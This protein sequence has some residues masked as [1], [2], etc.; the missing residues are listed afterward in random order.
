ETLTYAELDQR[1]NSLAHHLITTHHTRP[2]DLIA[3]CLPR[4]AHLIT[5]L[6]AILKTGAAYVPLDPHYPAQRTNHLITDSNATLLITTSTT[7]APVS[8][9][10]T[11]LVDELEPGRGDLRPNVPVAPESLAYTIYTSGSTGRPKGVM[12]EHRQTTAMLTWARDTFP[13][14]V[15]ARTLASTSIC[16]DLSVFE[17]FAPL[18]TGGTVVLTPD[19]ALDL[20]HN[21]DAYRDV[22]LINTVPSIASELLAANA[23][24]PQARTINLAGEALSPKL[25]T[26]LLALPTVSTVNNL[27][28]PSED[29]T[30]STHAITT[31]NDPRT[32]IGRPIHGTTAHVLDNQ[33]NPV[34]LGTIGELYL[35]GAGITRG[36]HNQPATT[37]EKYLP[38]PNGQRLYRTGDL[39][40]WRTDGQL[41]YHGR[42]DNQTKIRGHRI[43]PEEIETVLRA[44]PEVTAATVAA[45]A[46]RLVGY[47][48]SEGVGHAELADHLRARLPEQ[49]VPSVFVDLAELPMTPNG[50]VDRN[51]LPEPT[52]ARA[53]LSGR[54]PETVDE[55]LVARVW[56]EVLDV[57]ESAIGVDD[58]FFRLGGHS[59]LA[60]RLVHRLGAALGAAVPLS[61][62]FDHPSVAGQARRLPRERVEPIPVLGRVA[63][64]D[65]SVVLPASAGQQRLWVLCQ[66]D[67]DANRAYHITGAAEVDGALDV[68]VLAEAV[69]RAAVRHEALRT[70]L[71]EVDEELVQVV[72]PEPRAGLVEGDWADELARPLNLG[73]GRALWKAVLTRTGPD[74]HVLG[75]SLHHAIADGWSVR[76]LLGEITEQYRALLTDPAAAEPEA[77]PVQFADVAAWQAGRRGDLAHWVEAS[78]GA[79]PLALATDRPRPARQTHGGAAVPLDLP[80]AELRAVASGAGTSV[81]AVLAA[82]VAVALAAGGGSRDITVG[83]PVSGREH[84]DTV[85]VLGFLVDTLP[86]RLRAEPTMT[87]AQVVAAAT[88]AARA[89]ARRG[90]VSFADLVRELAPERDQSRSPV[91]QVMVA[92]NGTPG[93]YE[94][95]GLRVRPVPVAPTATPFDLVFQV[96]EDGERVDGWL[97]RNTD[98][99]DESTARLLVRRVGTVVEAM[100][101][102]PLTALA[103]LDVR[104]ADERARAEDLARGVPQAP[105]GTCAHEL[106]QAQ[107]D[108]TPDAI[109]LRAGDGNLT[110][111]QLDRAANRLAHRLRGLGVG[112]E[113]R[114][115]VC[116]PRTSRL[117]VSL[118]GVLASGAAY[119][120]VDPAYPAERIELLL[121][122]SGAAVLITDEGGPAPDGVV[123]LRSAVEDG[124]VERVASGV[125]ADNLAYVIHTSGSTG[126]PKGVMIEHRQTTAMLT[127]ARDTF[128]PEVLA[129]T[130]AATSI[131]FDL[132]VFEIFAPLTTGGTITLAPD[133]ALDLIHN[134]DAYH[135]LTLVNTVPSAAAELLAADAIPPGARTINLA[136][137]ALSPALVD[138]LYQHPVLD[139]VNN[140]YGPSEDTTYSTHA[141]TTPNDPRTPIGR[142]IH[143]TTVHILDADLTPVPLGAIGELYLSGA[144]I[145]R[146]YHNQPATTAEKY[147]P[148]PNGQRLYRT[149]D[150]ARWRT[151]GQLDYHGRTDNQ[152]KIRGHRIE[153]EEVETTLRAHPGVLQAAVAARGGSLVGY[154]VGDVD[155]GEVLRT[156]RAALP[157]A[158]VPT[159]LVALAAMPMTPNGKVDRNA[160]PEP[161]S[162]RAAGGPP[163]TANE[164]LVAEIW[165][166]LLE[167]D[168]LGVDDDFFAVGGHSLLASRVVSR[169]AARTGTRLP[170][171][172]VF[173]HPTVAGLASHLPEVAAPVTIP[174]VRRTPHQGQRTR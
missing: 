149:G 168:E 111:A 144:G 50:K 137:E 23:L 18:T 31:P 150:L 131:C 121:A 32:P 138:Q 159:R 51:A 98:L 33:L 112:P 156:A 11:A 103:E 108:R 119:V 118:L 125:G 95:P 37:A 136:G 39:A 3:V 72:S 115:A 146:G 87:L 135:H 58:D 4:T 71:R 141:I 60:T 40:R 62:V 10:P 107:V 145:T 100:A 76:V 94:L 16:F 147:L 67:P 165:T 90:H 56:A 41:D 132:S 47:V 161:T 66:L 48:V 45:R 158:L 5:T 54:A 7:G 38:A 25:V 44:H 70:V 77:A 116:L 65:G 27:Y 166:E 171:R 9:R 117:V 20:I 106:V 155:P 61:L 139:T 102:A 114:V 75:V 42:T 134:P 57:P 142:P 73:G 64:P 1:A 162:A 152:T 55:R 88:E 69:R 85:G 105:S 17:I 12:I 110:Y 14:E 28:G 151:D 81:F 130:L 143:G 8:G 126:R 29:T 133:N 78:R 97:V 86:L 167:L 123:V 82:A 120:P 6:L 113:D 43:E 84:P 154:V 2:G 35:S 49:F 164:R 52:S 109:A 124:P 128:P 160:L 99:F 169:I 96:E 93:A 92:V 21:P 15:V 80:V 53:E 174:R 22:T 36:Y 101:A 127:W 34:P 24:P 140:L 74:R 172:A 173:D 79:P 46:G 148:A 63:G 83:T 129:E 19:N 68:G 89:V 13:P 157:P 122:D 91:F 153:P 170:L 30:Y 104:P 163:R 26:E 59:L